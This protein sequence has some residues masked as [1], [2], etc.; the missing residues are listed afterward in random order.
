MRLTK[1]CFH[2][3]PNGGTAKRNRAKSGNASDLRGGGGSEVLSNDRPGQYDPMKNL[4]LEDRTALATEFI[5]SAQSK[6]ERKQRQSFVDASDAAMKGGVRQYRKNNTVVTS[7]NEIY[8]GSR[9]NGKWNFYLI[10]S[11]S[12][13]GEFVGT[14]T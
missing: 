3:M 4:S 11:Y 1:T 14:S 12:R 8:A 13:S 5:N 7:K 2:D 9:S 6:S 10:G